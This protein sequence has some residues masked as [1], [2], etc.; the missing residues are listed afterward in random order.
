MR[1]LAEVTYEGIEE[2]KEYEAII[3]KVYEACFKEENLLKR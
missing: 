2:N 1:K 3:D